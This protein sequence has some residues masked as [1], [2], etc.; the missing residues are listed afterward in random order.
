[1]AVV[2]IE[3][4]PQFKPSSSLIDETANDIAAVASQPNVHAIQIDFDAT[5]S[6]RDFYTA[7]I[8][9]LH[10]KLPPAMPISITALVSWCGDNSWLHALPIDEAVPMFFRMGG[11][12]ATRASAPRNA[13]TITE[14]LCSN[15]IGISTDEAWPN[16]QSTQRV[17]MFRPG[18]WT[19][20]DLA[21]INTLGYQG[22]RGTSK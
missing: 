14:P 4:G 1:M 8:K 3:T 10:T 11:P 12:T 13:S 5:A 15:S 17:Y 19:Q 16:I 6:Q 7:I 22:L 9:S 20:K 21:N 18:S 2:R